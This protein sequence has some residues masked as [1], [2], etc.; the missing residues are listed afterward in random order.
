VNLTEVD[1]FPSGEGFQSLFG[2][3][4]FEKKWYRHVIL[5]GNEV[6]VLEAAQFLHQEGVITSIEIYQVR[7]VKPDNLKFPFGI[8]PETEE[9]I[10]L[11]FENTHDLESR[12]HK[13]LAVGRIC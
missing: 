6:D 1:S 8:N 13:Y 5:E 11:S 3:S 4:N 7:A 10:V 12:G 9:K 2:G